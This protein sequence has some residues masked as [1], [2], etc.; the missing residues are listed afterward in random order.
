[1]VFNYFV[2][3]L[4]VIIAFWTRK[5]FIKVLDM[6]KSFDSRTRDLFGYSRKE[7]AT[8]VWAWSTC[9]LTASIWI[10]VSRSGMIAFNEYWIDNTTYFLNYLVNSVSV[11][12]FS[13]VV[14]LLGQRFRLLNRIAKRCSQECAKSRFSTI[15]LKV[16]LSTAYG[17]N[18]HTELISS[19]PGCIGDTTDAQQFNERRRESTISVFIVP[20]VVAGKFVLA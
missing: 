4:N 1:M 18:H 11:I 17:R 8:K 3:V 9:I 10:M 15:D 5:E 19:V 6:V 2:G 12:K 14:L 13:S 7:G 20:S 16:S